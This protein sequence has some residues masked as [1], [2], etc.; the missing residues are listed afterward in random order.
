[1]GASWGGIDPITN[2][3]VG[4]MDRTKDDHTTYDEWLTWMIINHGVDSDITAENI[5]KEPDYKLMTA[6][7][8]S[9]MVA[10]DTNNGTIRITDKAQRYLR[11]LNDSDRM[12]DM[13][14][15]R[16]E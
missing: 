5:A 12:I 9:H 3:V 15:E 14:K 13:I 10:S 2:R 1:M 16:N 4:I 11:I 6:M 7:A 8:S